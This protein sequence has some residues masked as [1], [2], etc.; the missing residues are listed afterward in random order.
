[1]NSAAFLEYQHYYIDQKKDSGA[2]TSEVKQWSYAIGLPVVGILF[3]YFF[4][5]LG[6]A[7]ALLGPCV[8]FI[9]ARLI[10]NYWDEKVCSIQT[11][12]ITKGQ[13]L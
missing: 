12:E 1:M 10:T 3:L 2:F 13:I 11:I 8:I 4:L 5:S 9:A 6:G 7:F